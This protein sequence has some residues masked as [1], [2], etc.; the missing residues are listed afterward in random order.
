M[1]AIIEL[2]LG[3]ISK[4]ARHRATDESGRNILCYGKELK[5]VGAVV[6]IFWIALII[7]VFMGVFEGT[8]EDIL[9]VTALFA[10]LTTTGI[11]ILIEAYF[12]RIVYD[13]TTITAYSPWRRDIRMIPWSDIE[14]IR[15]S[16]MMRWYICKTKNHGNLI[17]SSYLMGLDDFLEELEER[18]D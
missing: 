5:I 2:I 15:Y 11:A 6:T 3:W 9:W 10:F 4:G 12:V 8:K 16:G 14:S 7:L 1:E 13:E 18:A 17:L